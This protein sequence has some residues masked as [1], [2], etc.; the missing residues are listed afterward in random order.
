MEHHI[1]ELLRKEC[2]FQL[3]E[4]TLDKFLG[5][6]DE[7][8][9]K[10]REVLVMTGQTDPDI[11]IVKEGILSHTYLDGQK[12]RTAFFSMP[13]TM[14]F[15]SHCFYFGEPALYQVEACC[16]TTLLHIS[17][18][19]FDELAADSHEFCRW[20]LSMAQ[21]QLY[22]Y[23]MKQ[24]VIN[25]NARERFKSLMDRRPEI[26]ARVPM[27]KIASYLG[28]TQSY[29]CRLKTIYFEAPEKF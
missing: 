27:K 22:F 23:E 3:S 26:M 7:R 20:A 24:A 28:I 19:R 13:G 14:T 16:P 5:L 18:E 9:L 29:L 11:Y 10:A 12:E 6:M 1:K 15:S 2:L 4:P 21:C 8:C 17:K 25:G